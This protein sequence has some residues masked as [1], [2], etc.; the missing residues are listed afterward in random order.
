MHK[1]Q[2]SPLDVIRKPQVAP[3]LPRL[4]ESFGDRLIDALFLGRSGSLAAPVRINAWSSANGLVRRVNPFS[5]SSGAASNPAAA[6]Q[7]CASSFGRTGSN[8]SKPEVARFVNPSP[9]MT[10]RTQILRPS[11]TRACIDPAVSAQVRL[12]KHKSQ[13]GSSCPAPGEGADGCRSQ[14]SLQSRGWRAVGSRIGAD[15]CIGL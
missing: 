4:I 8:L 10:D 3:S 12:L 5:E 14:S 6:H 7:G 9:F 15:V 1:L 2:A 11:S 13:R